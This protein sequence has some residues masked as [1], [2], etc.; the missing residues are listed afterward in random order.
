M[1]W[2]G[3]EDRTSCAKKSDCVILHWIRILWP[4]DGILSKLNRFLI[5]G[6][7]RIFKRKTIHFQDV[8]DLDVVC[9]IF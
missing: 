9:S 4:L 1:Y 2:R 6:H 7:L 8:D 3:S 5:M